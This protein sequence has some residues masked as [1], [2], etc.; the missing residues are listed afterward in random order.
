MA[1]FQRL[2]QPNT[3]EEPCL[4][5]KG[6]LNNVNPELLPDG[7]VSDMENLETTIEGMPESI[8]NPTLLGTIASGNI[9]AFFAWQ[10]DDGTIIYLCQ[11]GT[12]I[13]RWITDAWFRIKTFTSSAK[14]SFASGMADTVYIVH[15]V[16]GLWSYTGTLL[17]TAL[18]GTVEVVTASTAVVG[19]TTA[20]DTELVVGDR[21][22][23]GTETF[24]VSV[25]TNATHL[26]L[27]SNYLGAGASG[28]TAY[29]DVKA[30]V[31]SAH[32]NATG[33]YI[34]LWKNRF[35]VA[36][37]TTYPQRISWCKINDPTDWTTADITGVVDFRT[38]EDSRITGIIPVG[39][40][41]YVTSESASFSLSGYSNVTFE[42]F[43][44]NYSLDQ[45][46]S[47]AIVN[48]EGGVYFIG[49]DGIF[50]VG[51]RNT[52][53]KRISMP[54]DS[55]V[56]YTSAIKSC[57][58]WKSKVYFLI[59]TK[60]FILN[61]VTGF[62]EK[63]SYSSMSLIYSFDHL[64]LGTSA[65]SAYKLD[66][67][68]T[69]YLTWYLTTKVHNEGITVLQKRYK[70]LYVF[71]KTTSTANTI[72]VDLYEDYSNQA[73]RI[74][75]FDTSVGATGAYYQLVATVDADAAQWGYDVYSSAYIGNIDVKKLYAFIGV[76][77][78]VSLKFSG[79]G[80]VGLLGYTL[81]FKPKR[82]I[83]V[84]A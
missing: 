20:F 18:T 1:K 59:G 56:D 19:T 30:V 77:R 34:T 49:R 76:A 27:S 10:K 4:G 15:P 53:P 73:Q 58:Y 12:K 72:N 46:V 82:R 78:T 74:G 52:P 38:A 26:T 65:G 14:V 81:A 62:W 79:E 60:I 3:W 28:L 24:T 44:Y 8:A 80:R 54:I 16:D 83:G 36:G 37:N 61:L 55:L 2:P 6:I 39:D 5:F 25:I 9:I 23:I 7:Y 41:L 22:K 84:R 48:A 31:V 45:P 40:I 32:A 75:S 33:K 66:V 63:R 64:W 42:S 29:T 68:T 51:E 70:T 35:F 67:G 11:S 71:Y 21:I 47:N 43:P 57:A 50:S 17:V 69:G 13:Y